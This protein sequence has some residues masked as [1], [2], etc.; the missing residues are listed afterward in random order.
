MEDRA[1]LTSLLMFGEALIVNLKLSEGENKKRFN[2]LTSFMLTYSTNKATCLS[3]LKYFIE[4]TR[5][6]SPYQ[7]DAF[8]AY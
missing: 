3:W 7:V 1:M 6:N 2:T 5:M 4:G 8:L